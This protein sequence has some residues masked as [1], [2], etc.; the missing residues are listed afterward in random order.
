MKKNNTNTRQSKRPLHLSRNTVR[1]L[2]GQQL[3]QVAGGP[4]L[5][6]DLAIA[7]MPTLSDDQ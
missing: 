7:L 3:R 5:A 4:T 6:G 1:R 2:D